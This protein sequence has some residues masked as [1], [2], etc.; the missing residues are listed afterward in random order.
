MKPLPTMDDYGGQPAAIYELYS[1][2]DVAIAA[3]RGGPLSGAALLALNHKTLG[4]GSRAW[5]TLAIG[6]L[7]NVA[8]MFSSFCLGWGLIIGPAYAIGSFLALG[9]WT[10]Y[11][12]LR[13]PGYPTDHLLWS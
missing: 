13:M 7:L 12:L 8:F 2:W 10:E 9:Y 4:D 6:S 1:P 3:F 11:N 5:S